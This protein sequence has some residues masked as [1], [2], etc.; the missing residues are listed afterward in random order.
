MSF[1]WD[2]QTD[3]DIEDA[4]QR[5]GPMTERQEGEIRDALEANRERFEAWRKLIPDARTSSR[6]RQIWTPNGLMTLIYCTNCGA[7]GGAVTNDTPFI[8]FYCEKCRH[9]A[10]GLPEVP[11]PVVRPKEA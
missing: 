3:R 11:E 7:G 2:R 4:K 1:L 10:A 8:H 5:N 6:Q 9:L